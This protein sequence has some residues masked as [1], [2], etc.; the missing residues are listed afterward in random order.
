[1]ADKLPGNLTNQHQRI[2]G[3]LVRTDVRV[4]GQLDDHGTKNYNRLI[5][6]P[7]IEGVTLE[8]NKTFEEL[9]LRPVTNA[10]LAALLD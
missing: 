8:G 6:K 7:S 10:E 5:N 9:N 1:M 3:S 2:E 4:S